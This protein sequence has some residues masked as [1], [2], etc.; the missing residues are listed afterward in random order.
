[1]SASRNEGL[2]FWYLNSLFLF[3]SSLTAAAP[4]VRMM[5]QKAIIKNATVVALVHNH[6]SGNRN[7]STDDD[8][9]TERVKNAC[10]IMR[11]H[12]LD[13]LI[14]AKDKYYSYHEQGRL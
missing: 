10:K 6:P 9:L 11:L 7:P 12:L 5:I 13:H 14:V 3:P 4:D 2:S 8:R 1:V